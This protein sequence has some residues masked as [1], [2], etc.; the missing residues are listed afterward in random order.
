MFKH[1]MVI[2]T[3]SG[4]TVNGEVNQSLSPLE[5]QVEI[6]AKFHGKLMSFN[7]IVHYL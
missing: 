6:H 1:N 3:D 2:I 5:L 7:K 4:V